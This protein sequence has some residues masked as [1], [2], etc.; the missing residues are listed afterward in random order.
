MTSAS[1]SDECLYVLCLYIIV[2]AVEDWWNAED[3]VNI[4]VSQ[5]AVRRVNAGPVLQPGY[6]N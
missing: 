1:G 3:A 6:A 2:P 5:G 4:G